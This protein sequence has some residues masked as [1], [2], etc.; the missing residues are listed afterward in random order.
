MLLHAAKEAWRRNDRCIGRLFVD[1]LELRDKRDLS[2]ATAIID[3]CVEHINV[4]YNGGNVLPLVTVYRPGFRILNHLLLAYA[5]DPLH[6][7]LTGLLA[8]RGWHPRR[9]FQLLPV[10]VQDAAGEIWYHDIPWDQAP[11]VDVRSD[12][13]PSLQKLG[14]RWPALPILSDVELWVSED[15]VYTAAPFNGWYVETEIG[16]RDLVDEGRYNL[17]PAVGKDLK[18]DTTRDRSLWKDEAVVVLC[19]A[20]LDS[21]QRAGVSIVDHHTAGRQFR[22]F[23]ESEARAGREVTGEWAWL[24]PPVSP[25][26]S[27]VWDRQYKKN[28]DGPPDFRYPEKVYWG[29]GGEAQSVMT[30]PVKIGGEFDAQRA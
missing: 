18:L 7:P 12:R 26:T 16:A 4:A 17:L 14:V 15:E 5:D 1:R 11:E 10:V 2:T 25:A 28:K 3:D 23:E 13:L 24:I 6:A 20:V 21:F 19:Q 29:N 22:A 27:A 9:P 8:S 30:C